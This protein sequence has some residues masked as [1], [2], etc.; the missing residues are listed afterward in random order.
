MKCPRHHFL[1]EGSESLDPFRP[2]L[3][4]YSEV[5]FRCY[6]LICEQQLL[7][8]MECDGLKELGF[9]RLLNRV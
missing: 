5:S 4:F 8:E 7:E 3:S 1:L 2:P 6:R 9:V